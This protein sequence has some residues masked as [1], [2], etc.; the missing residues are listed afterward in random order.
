L[1]FLQNIRQVLFPIQQ[2]DV[3]EEKVFDSSFIFPYSEDKEVKRQQIWENLQKG[4]LFE[5]T[6]VLIPW[7]TSFAGI[8]RIA[9]QRRNSGDRTEWFLGKHTV[10]D[11]YTCLAGVMKWLFVK[12]SEPFSRI[13][14]WLGADDEGNQKFLFLR[15]KFTDLLG[16]PSLSDLSEFGSFQ[17]G[18]LEW[19]NGNV[20]ISLSG[21]EQFA[22]K[23][24]L[25]IGLTTNPNWPEGIAGN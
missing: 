13:E 22:C 12:D 11:G 7:M 17:L 24:R 18:S 6:Q 10:M 9:E 2:Q 15:D 25:Y 1:G 5:D 14:E 20:R 23:Y 21:I 4:I 16:E 19:T 3:Q 8:N